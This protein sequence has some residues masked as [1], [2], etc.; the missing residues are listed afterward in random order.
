[1]DELLEENIESVEDTGFSYEYPILDQDNQEI[2]DPDLELGYLRKE[3]FNIHHESIPEQWHYKVVSFRFT[4]GEVYKVE[5]ENDSH[6]KIIDSQKGIF[7][8]QS[9]DGEPERTIVGQTIAPIIDNA[10]IPAWD[11][12]KTFYRYV[13]YTEKELSDKE[14]LASGPASLAEAQETIEDLLLVIADLLGGSEE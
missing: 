8:Y 5:D 2:T 10:L 6:V 12:I 9:L 14:F 7:N 4:D 1:M 13:P 3:E 11:E